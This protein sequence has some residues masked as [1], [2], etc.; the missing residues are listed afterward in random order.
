MAVDFEKSETYKEMHEAFFGIQEDAISDPE[1][2]LR[3]KENGWPT[4]EK[5][6]AIVAKEP[7]LPIKGG[8]RI[9]RGGHWE[10]NVGG[11]GRSYVYPRIKGS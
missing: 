9:E 10:T 11:P 5:L 7:V 8:I 1:Q 2:G 6:R 4:E 3:P